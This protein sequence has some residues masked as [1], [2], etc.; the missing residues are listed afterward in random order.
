VATY[1]LSNAGAGYTTTPAV[2]VSAPPSGT[3]ATATATIANGL[4]TGFT[5]TN[6]GSL[7]NSPPV[8]TVDPPP[9]GVQ[10]TATCVLN[11]LSGA[12]SGVG[13]VFTITD[14]GSGYPSAPAVTIGGSVGVP[15]KAT[16]ILTNGTV[17]GYTL[18]AAGSGYTAAPTV[19]I[20]GPPANAQATAS[21]IVANG[22]VTGFTVNGGGSG[23]EKSPVVLIGLPPPRTGSSTPTPF[24]LRTLLHLSDGGTARLLSEVYL[25]QLAAAPNGVGLCTSESLL[26]QDALGSAKC[27]TSSHLPMDQIITSGSGSFATGQTL[28]RVIHVPYD[29]ATNPFVHAYHPDHDNKDARGN[30]L[31]ATE[32]ASG[33]KQTEESHDIR[34]T[35]QFIFTASPPAGSSVTSG[36]GSS[37][38]GGNYIETMTGVHKDP[39]ILS[40]TFELRRASQ[41]GTLSQ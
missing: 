36:W 15:A 31:S 8:V 23:Y 22:S 21:A 27:F 24:K 13:T 30:W 33:L 26:K 38:I 10:A 29:D 11:G 2:S 41:I 39:I 25:G 34:R 18:T 37:V 6:P 32:D 12:N 19:N 5:I 14:P 7:Y 17:T 4:V 40:G 1:S 35:C 3:P 20:S 28:T 16:A 9:A